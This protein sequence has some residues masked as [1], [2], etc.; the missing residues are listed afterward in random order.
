SQ[1]QKEIEI[2]KEKINVPKLYEDAK[3]NSFEDT[4]SDN[5]NEHAKHESMPSAEWRHRMVEQQEK[6]ARQSNALAESVN[7]PKR[8]SFALQQQIKTQVDKQERRKSIIKKKDVELLHAKAEPKKD[9]T[10]V[11]SDEPLA[12]VHDSNKD[13]PNDKKHVNNLE[14]PTLALENIAEGELNPTQSIATDLLS[15]R[16]QKE[17]EE[18]EK[19]SKQ[20]KLYC[21]R[22]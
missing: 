5:G 6:E 21:R 2:E 10:I 9:D 8:A 15:P 4:L 14:P 22:F 13:T 19:R 11:V 7:L 17:K 20:A 1:Q 18:K 12:K 3:S 16:L